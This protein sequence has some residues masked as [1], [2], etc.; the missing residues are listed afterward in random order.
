MEL[1]NSLN[2]MRDASGVPFYPVVFQF[3]L[4]LTFALHIMFVNF[5]LGGVVVSIWARIKATPNSLR[6]SKALARASTIN[7]SLAMVLGVAPL[8]FVQV[9]YDPF[10]YTANSMSAYWAMAFLLILAVAFTASYVFY[11]SGSDKAPGA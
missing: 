7:A 11:L 6:L 4:V 2:A 5:L 9:I 10:W 3:F 1:T 8:L